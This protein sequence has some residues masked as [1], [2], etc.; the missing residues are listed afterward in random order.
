MCLPKQSPLCFL[1]LYMLVPTAH[2]LK[3]D[4]K[5]SRIFM[6]LP[7]WRVCKAWG[8]P[9]IRVCLSVSLTLSLSLC[10]WMCVCV[11]V[12]FCVCDK[13]LCEVCHHC[14]ILA[15]LVELILDLIFFNESMSIFQTSS[16]SSQSL[17]FS[18]SLISL[19][20]PLSLLLPLPKFH[21]LL[22]TLFISVSVCL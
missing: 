17:P 1:Q 11:C 19:P 15:Q 10:E 20:S 21:P 22:L 3:I 16:P 13:V 14:S 8:F 4:E 5:M 18:V 6:K 7:H 2:F 12:Y 9:H